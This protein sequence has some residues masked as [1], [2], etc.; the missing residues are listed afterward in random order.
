[1]TARRNQ[2]QYLVTVVEEGQ[3]TRAARRLQL[4]Q[5]ALSQA[6]ASLESE[7]GVELLTRHPRGVTLTP[8]GAAFLIKARASLAAETDAAQTAELLA[9]A[10]RGALVVGFVGSPPALRAPALFQALAAEYPDAHVTYQDLS[11]PCGQTSSWLSPVDVVLCHAPR[12]EAGVRRLTLRAEPRAVVLPAGH[13]LIARDTLLLEDVLDEMFLSYHGDVQPEWAGFH[14][15][16]DHRGAQ[17]AR[18]VAQHALNSLQMLGIMSCGESITALPE[19]D[20]KL[21]SQVLP[22]F[23]AVPVLDAAPADVALVWREDNPN[24]LVDALVQVATQQAMSHG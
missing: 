2:L 16:D 8:A 6:I 14:S 10:A 13:P 5:P 12:P 7:L 19:S 4:A 24:G 9:R 18:A 15:F 11:F 1:M 23:E 22:G 3:I 17:P 20:A 21:V